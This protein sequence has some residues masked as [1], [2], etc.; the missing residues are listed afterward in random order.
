MF[1]P[2]PIKPPSPYKIL[3]DVILLVLVCRQS[4][5]FRIERRHRTDNYA[6][7]SNEVIIQNYEKVDFENPYIDHMTY[8]KCVSK[9]VLFFPW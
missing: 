1:L 5:G 2:D 3:C 8:T 4:L 7:G 9:K 6:G